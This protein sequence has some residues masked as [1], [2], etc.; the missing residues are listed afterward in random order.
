MTTRAEL[1]IAIKARDEASSKLDGVRGKLGG[2]LSDLK[3]T[4]LP[5]AAVGAGLIAAANNYEKA[6]A[7]IRTG[8]GATGEAFEKLKDDYE[9][10]SGTVRASSQ[11]IA[12]TVAD[13]NTRLGLTGPLLQEVSRAAIEADIDINQVAQAMSIMGVENDKAVGFMDA[14]FVASQKTGIPIQDLISQL[15]TYGPVLANAN[16]TQQESIALMA[17]LNAAG[18]DASRVFPGLNAFFRRTAEEGG[19]LKEALFNVVGQMESAE[20]WTQALAIATEAFGAEGAQRLV[21]AVRDGSFALEDMVGNLNNAKGA[22]ADNTE[23]TTT[24]VDRMKM[25]KD[26][27]VER[28]GAAVLDLAEEVFP[29]LLPALEEAINLIDLWVDAFGFL[30]RAYDSKLGWLLPGGIFIK[31]LQAVVGN[32]DAIKGAWDRVW[33]FVI[34]MANEVTSGVRE[35]L[36]SIIESAK[37]MLDAIPGPNKYGDAMQAAIDKI[38]G[39][40]PEV[41]EYDETVKQATVSME[42]AVPVVKDVDASAA[43]L[44]GTLDQA[45]GSLVVMDE[46]MQSVGHAAIGMKLP[47]DDVTN[48]IRGNEDALQAARD[49]LDNYRAPMSPTEEAIRRMQDAIDAKKVAQDNLNA[50]IDDG[51]ASV[52]EINRAIDQYESSVDRAAKA[53]QPLIDEMKELASQADATWDSIMNTG[54]SVKSTVSEIEDARKRVA[55]ARAA[56]LARK[57]LASSGSSPHDLGNRLLAMPGMLQAANGVQNFRGG[58]ALVGER[59]PELVNLPR[60]SDVIPNHMIGRGMGGNVT[61]HITVQGSILATDLT[62]LIEERLRDIDERSGGRVRFALG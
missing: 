34:D 13:A 43:S 42:Q 44:I 21:T 24:M 54:E 57:A 33:T 48:A 11:E 55:D 47:I 17:Q 41:Q 9:A 16:F 39:G 60:G 3:K 35:M 22:I 46:N 8:T 25:L 58:L 15:Q 51:T 5:A 32:L 59:G 23:A 20:N 29:I 2:L 52:E 61:L 12:S 30:K 31:G 4:A 50:I 37:D 26:E 45:S 10:L 28:V 53:M 40:I 7:T 1:D 62:D 49:A 6:L 36:A 56:D 19:N 27:A 14:L 38:R 18:V